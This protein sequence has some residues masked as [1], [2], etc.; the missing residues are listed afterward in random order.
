MNIIGLWLGGVVLIISFIS[1]L[2]PQSFW[3]KIIRSSS[4]YFITAILSSSLIIWW[5]NWGFNTRRTRVIYG[6]VLLI[7]G[8]L[9]ILATGGLK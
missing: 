2:A 4:K 3:L 7:L 6:A 9:F 1:L 5:E 8:I